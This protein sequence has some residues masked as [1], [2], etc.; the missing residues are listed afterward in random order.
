VAWDGGIRTVHTSWEYHFEYIDIFDDFNKIEKDVEHP[1]LF[2]WGFDG[3]LPRIGMSAYNPN[4]IINIVSD[5][6]VPVNVL[7]TRWL[8]RKN[9]DYK[10]IARSV[11]LQGLL[12]MDE[13]PQWLPVD[14]KMKI[15]NFFVTC[16]KNGLRAHEA[17]LGWVLGLDEVDHVIVGVNSAKQ[18]EQLLQVEP[19]E[20]EYDF[21]IQDEN[22][23]DPR[24]WPKA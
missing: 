21:S 7:D 22:V 14:A 6:M 5:I 24:R 19:L 17:A 11:F 3:V 1:E 15:L 23:L 16:A 18:L 4:E 2:R 9:P 20:W 12:L 10:L 8:A 13:L